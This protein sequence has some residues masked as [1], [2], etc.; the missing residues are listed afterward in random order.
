MAPLP[1]DTAWSFCVIFL[2]VSGCVRFVNNFA[3]VHIGVSYLCVHELPFVGSSDKRFQFL[4]LELDGGLSSWSS[5]LL[6]RQHFVDLPGFSS[7]GKFVCRVLFQWHVPECV[8]CCSHWASG[9]FVCRVIFHWHVPECVSC[10]SHR[11]HGKLVCRVIFQWHVPECVSYSS[12]WSSFTRPASTAFFQ[13]HL[14]CITHTATA[15]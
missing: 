10:S 6:F 11:V 1:L 2:L 13:E 12:H 7:C 14:A 8:S 3:C 15:R 9:K 5:S 4:F